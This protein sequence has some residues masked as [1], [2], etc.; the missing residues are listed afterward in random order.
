VLKEAGI[1]DALEPIVGGP[2][3]GSTP[4]A[5]ASLVQEAVLEPNT[6][7]NPFDF[8]AV[9][10]ESA[11][12]EET[13]NEFSLGDESMQ[14]WRRVYRGLGLVTVATFLGPAVAP[15]ALIMPFVILFV[16][17]IGLITVEDLQTWLLPTLILLLWFI[18]LAVAGVRTVGVGYCVAAPSNAGVK[19]LAIAALVLNVLLTLCGAATFLLASFARILDDPAFEVFAWLSLIPFG[20]LSVMELIVFLVFLLQVA[21]ALRRSELKKEV[22]RFFIWLGVWI[23]CNAMLGILLGVFGNA[24]WLSVTCAMVLVSF[25]IRY[26]L[27]LRTARGV[28][29]RLFRLNLRAVS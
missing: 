20:P 21:N 1:A 29:M 11:S 22:I 10:P 25:L 28:L 19:G 5:R 14:A 7:V 13:G 15:V 9:A 18:P 16:G 4:V 6:S 8:D 3:Q 26:L 24:L 12:A 2:A 17:A 23:V 27:L